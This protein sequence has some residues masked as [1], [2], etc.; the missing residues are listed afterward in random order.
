MAKHF[1]FTD[2]LEA[3]ERS[4]GLEAILASS[5]LR[6]LPQ[7]ERTLLQGMMRRMPV[8]D[9]QVL[10]EEGERDG[11]LVLVLQGRVDA[12]KAESA[13]VWVDMGAYGRIDMDDPL[14][15]PQQLL[16]SYA[17]GECLGE[18]GFCHDE[19]HAFTAVCVGDGEVLVLQASDLK[20]VLQQDP[21]AGCRLMRSLREMVA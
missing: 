17:T 15:C 16:H 14:E 4:K 1:H 8:R 20:P 6:N 7:E 13:P 12:V 2:L 11:Q 9:G 5:R 18:Q 21:Q 10:F 19:P 3:Q